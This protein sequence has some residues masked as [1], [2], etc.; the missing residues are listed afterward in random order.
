MY[1]KELIQRQVEEV[2][3]YSQDIN[4]LINCQDWIQQWESAK[5]SFI[6]D[7]HDQLIYEIPNVS[8]SLGLKERQFKLESFRERIRVY[9]GN[10]ELANF[11][12]WIE[13]DD[14][15]NNLLSTG[16]YYQDDCIPAGY[17][18]VK[19]FKFFEEDKSILTDIQNEA[20]RII[21]TNKINGTLCFSV[22]P[23]DY[24]SVSE[25]DHNWRSCHALDGDYRAGNVSYMLDT[26][27]VVCYLRSNEPAQLPNFPYSVPWNSK[28]WR[29]LLFFSTDKSMCFAG[30]QYPFATDNALDFIKN[31]FPNLGWGEWYDWTD[32]KIEESPNGFFFE[33]PYV[34]IGS[35]LIAMDKLM[36]EPNSVL[37]FNDLLYSSCYKAQYTYRYNNGPSLHA[38]H[39][40]GWT[41]ECTRFKIG[42]DVLCPCCHTNYITEHET[43]LCN[44]CLRE[45]ENEEDSWYCEACGTKIRA[46]EIHWTTNDEPLCD[47]C[48]A[49]ETSECPNCGRIVWNSDITI[50]RENNNRKVCRYCMPGL[51]PI[52]HF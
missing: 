7:F 25:N 50:D 2:I 39:P 21:Q 42:A 13:L 44:N 4:Q 23:L 5:S 43:M 17:K 16:Y 47:H 26:S 35:E 46:D 3:T 15:Y 14:F 1:D 8:F 19:A 49:T 48:F 33:Y 12:Q 11:L 38:M 6:K 10:V 51:F 20:S 18:V 37:Y 24:L 36:I 28:K 52:L 40:T 32:K 22:H 45:E 41:T 30:R 9:Y 29:V 27:T 31:I 34:A